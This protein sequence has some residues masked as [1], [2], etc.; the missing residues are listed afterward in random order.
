MVHRGEIVEKAIRES[1][2]P[3]ATLAKKIGRSRR[4]LYNI[5]E[6]NKVSWD[7]IEEIGRIINH[8]FSKNFKELRTAQANV[9]RDE[10]QIYLTKER[11]LEEIKGALSDLRVKYIEL[12]EKYNLLLSAQLPKA[13]AKGKSR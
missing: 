13:K 8:D 5:F 6:N 11:E 12:L 2:Y 3:I 7:V 1:G 4:H 9:M 10:R